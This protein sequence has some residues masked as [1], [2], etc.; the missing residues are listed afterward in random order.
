MIVRA[1]LRARWRRKLGAWVCAAGARRGRAYERAASERA[2]RGAR[3][4]RSFVGL[5]R[6]GSARGSNQHGV[7]SV[8]LNVCA[9]RDLRLAAHLLE[10][11]A[12]IRVGGAVTEKGVRGVLDRLCVD[13][14]SERGP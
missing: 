1:W 5:I 7:L 11:G 14:G 9:R 8:P 6:V 10:L 2:A 3:G 13:W 4:T 12:H